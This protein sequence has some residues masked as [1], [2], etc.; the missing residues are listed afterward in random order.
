MTTYLADKISKSHVLI[1]FMGK[2]ESNNNVPLLQA[3]RMSWNSPVMLIVQ[4][5][6]SS[7]PLHGP[8]R[9]VS[10][11]PSSHEHW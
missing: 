4:A 5:E 9:G 2:S 11:V 7:L 3:H 10:I 6:K 1:D 8:S